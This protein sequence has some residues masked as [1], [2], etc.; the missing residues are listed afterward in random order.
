MND[1]NCH[2]AFLGEMFFFWQRLLLRMFVYICFSVK[3]LKN[4]I[5]MA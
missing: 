3:W 2:Q 1:A 4:F 5:F